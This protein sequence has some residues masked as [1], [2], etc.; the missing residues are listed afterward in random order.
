MVIILFLGLFDL[1]VCRQTTTEIYLPKSSLS[2]FPANDITDIVVYGNTIWFG[3]SK[4]LISTNND[5]LNFTL[6][7]H[8]NGLVKGDISTVNV[9]Y[10]GTIWISTVFDSATSIGDMEVG[11][12]LSYSTDNGIT[13]NW[14]PQPVDAITD[15][16][17]GKKPTTVAVTNVTWD[18]AF[19]DN[20]IWIAS[21]AG[22]LRKSTDDGKTWEVVTP[23]GLPFDVLGNLNHRPFSVINAQNGLWLGTAAGI[24]KSTDGG[25][26][27]T[28]YNAQNGSGISGNFV[29]CLAEQTFQG[30]S[31]IWASTWKAEDEEED[32]GVSMT[33]N[34]G[35][36]WKIL[37]V[38]EKPHAFAFHENEAYVVTDNGLFK[39]AD[40]G[41]TWGNFPQIVDESGNAIFTTEMYSVAVKSNDLWVGTGDGLANTSDKGNSWKIFRAFEPTGTEKESATYAY[42]NPF[43]PLRHNLIGGEG[44][45][46]IQYNTKNNTSVSIKIFDFGMN[47]VRNLVSDKSRPGGGD[48]YEV[49]DGRNENGVIVANGVYF[50]KLELSG[51]KTA[52]GKIVVLN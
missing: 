50:Y 8:E 39:T 38:G 35:L 27:W 3:T 17:G 42:P 18:I 4:G 5:G 34:G 12:G 49:W 9:S 46:R 25:K 15:T 16:A 10:D 29:N 31:I 41:K 14:I 52:W 44:H 6:Y 45:V 11:G 2:R 23:D 7:T 24:N 37:L 21:W 28:N 40:F 32:Y 36:T 33:E 22:G 47:L 26:T 20:D 51:E 1:S 43:S 19:R 30:K 13:W 48:Y